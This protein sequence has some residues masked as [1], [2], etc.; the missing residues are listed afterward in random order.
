MIYKGLTVK[1][2]GYI[3]YRRYSTTTKTL[4]DFS[5]EYT[6]KLISYYNKMFMNGYT[7][8]CQNETM[9]NDY[10]KLFDDNGIKYTIAQCEQISI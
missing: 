5:P 3:L 1:K 2:D 7:I 10:K 6:K 8:M 9:L 4:K